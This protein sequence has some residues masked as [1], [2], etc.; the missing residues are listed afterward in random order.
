MMKKFYKCPICGKVVQVE[1]DAFGKLHCCGKPMEELKA[2]SQ[3]AAVEKHIPEVSVDGNIVTAV[4]G[5]VIHPMSV[6]HHIGWL[7]LETEKGGQFAYLDPENEPKAQF[8]VAEG[9]KAKAVYSYCN[10]HGL[11]VKEL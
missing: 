2:N 7:W 6:E 1:T 8:V 5:S 4:V 10:L 9:D 3:E 11:W